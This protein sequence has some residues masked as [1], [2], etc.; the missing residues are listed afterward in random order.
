M[1][2][3]FHRQNRLRLF[4]QHGDF[5]LE[6]QFA[7][8]KLC[9]AGKVRVRLIRLV[10][11][12]AEFEFNIG[13]IFFEG[14]ELADG[15][16]FEVHVRAGFVQQVDGLV[17]KETVGDVPLGEND[18]LP[19]DLRRNFHAV[20]LFI[21]MRNTAQ[22][23]D[24]LLDRRFIDRHGLEAALER[25]V[26]FDI[27]AVLVERCRADDLNLA[28]REGGLEDIR[29]VHRAFCVARAN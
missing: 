11:K 12:R 17:G 24:G 23:R 18:G 26:L 29:R 25:R 27:L 19:R 9:H 13:L 20:E 8:A 28:A 5:L 7:A 16:V 6:L 22:N 2:K 1:R 15:L 3:V 14:F 10:H 21:V 4:L